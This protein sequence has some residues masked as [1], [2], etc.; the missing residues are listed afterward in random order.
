MQTHALSSLPSTLAEAKLCGSTKY[1]T[2]TPCKHGH[3]TYRYTRDRMCAAC[4]IAKSAKHKKP[5]VMAVW[6]ESRTPQQKIEINVKRR[7]Y[8]QETRER[9]LLLQKECRTKSRANPEYV[10]QVNNYVKRYRTRVDVAAK[11]KAEIA[12]RRA[13]KSQRTPKWAN[14]SKIVEFYKSCPDGYH[15]D[16]VIPLRGNIV[17][18]LH[19]VENLQYLPAKENISKSNRYEIV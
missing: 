12:A 6:W 18:G 7:A 13:G 19:V 15:V 10:Q 1:Y 9:R 11:R 4:A 17:S 8:W 5:N 14:L 2:G 16:H 3:L